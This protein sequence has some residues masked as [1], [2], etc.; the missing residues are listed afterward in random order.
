MPLEDLSKYAN[1]QTKR[2][3]VAA[4][5]GRFDSHDDD[6]EWNAFRVQFWGKGLEAL[7]SEE[8]VIRDSNPVQSVILPDWHPVATLPNI[9]SV[10]WD[11]GLRSKILIRSEY[12]TAEE[13][14]ILS[15]AS[16]PNVFAVCGRA[17]IG[18]LPYS[19]LPSAPN[20]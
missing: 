6:S 1:E 12:R 10:I 18:A 5:K 4:N 8:P 2:I 9:V 19:S 13:A 16:H 20:I 11:L 14:A 3:G 17:G 7:E 15:S